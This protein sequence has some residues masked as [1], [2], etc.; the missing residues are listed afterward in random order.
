[1]CLY[2]Q[3]SLCRLNF[4]MFSIGQ[5]DTESV[6]S[7]DTFEVLGASNRIPTICGDN[8]GQHS[9][10]FLKISMFRQMQNNVTE[11]EIHLL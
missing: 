2:L 5:P 8:E 7:T 1:M 6:C 10:F 11:F 4:I 9:K 3:F